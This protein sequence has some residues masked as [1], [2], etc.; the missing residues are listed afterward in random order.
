MNW[1]DLAMAGQAFFLA[2]MLL[3][4]VAYVSLFSLALKPFRRRLRERGGWLELADDVEV[5]PPITVIL[6]AYNEE[7]VIVDCVKATL[8]L[9]YPGL[10]VVVVCDGPKDRTFDV[11]V[12]Q[13]DLRDAPVSLRDDFATNP[14]RRLMASAKFPQ[15]RV[16][17]K[18]N[19]GKADALNVGLNA[20]RTPLV[21]CCDADTLIEPQALRA[22]VRPF[23][24]DPSVVAASGALR[25]SND[26]RFK[27][28]QPIE[29]PAPS[30]WLAAVQV[31]EYVRAFYLGRM[32]FEPLSS[33]LIISGAFGLFSRH[34]LVAIGG[35]NPRTVGEDMDVVVRLHR[36]HRDKQ[37]PYAVRYVP[38]A[39]AWTEAPESLAMLKSQ[40]QRWQR[41]LC[42]VLTDHRR[43]FLGRRQGTPGVLGFSYFVL[44]EA[45]A[46][47]IELLGY[48]CVLVF[49]VLGF[50][51]WMVWLAML[52]LAMTMSAMVSLGALQVQQHYAPVV[53]RARDLWR[54]LG[55]ALL[56]ML[57][58]RALTSVWRVAATWR[59]MTGRAAKWDPIARKGFKR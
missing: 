12:E 16:I 27:G 3:M 58:I 25:L 19:G 51:N 48:L 5:W 8:G 2:Y 49:L 47:L 4:F 1:G 13:L 37:L 50:R 40:R 36:Y 31:L 46:P 14:V 42:E 44:F 43:M 6:P 38:G 30:N 29:V 20:A 32:G 26:V 10:E 35:Y 55:A 59:F 18:D 23:Q 24:D 52:V 9:D 28:G 56:E 7:A 53:S 33:M 11:L 45:L 15:L 54:L 17:L 34:A 39:V 41:G 21:C 22:L 57:V